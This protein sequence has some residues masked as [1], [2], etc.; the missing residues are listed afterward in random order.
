MVCLFSLVSLVLLGVIMTLY[1]NECG[2]LSEEGGNLAV[3]KRTAIF[4]L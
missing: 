4:F 1:G 3:V 2:Y